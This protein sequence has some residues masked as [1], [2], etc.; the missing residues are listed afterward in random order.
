MAEALLGKDAGVA[1]SLLDRLIAEGKDVSRL[2]EDLITFFR[3]LLLLRTA[4]DLK[5]LLELISGD[6]RFVEMAKRF[7]LD[8]LYLFIDILAKTQQEM[9]FSNHA[10]VYIESALL[11]MI[12]LEVAQFKYRRAVIRQLIQGL[13]RKWQNLERRCHGV[14][15]TDVKW[16]Y[17]YATSAADNPHNRGK[18]HRNHRKTFK[19]PT[20]KIN[21]VLKAATK[22]DIQTIRE[23][24]AGMMQTMQKSHAALLEETEPVAASENAFVLKFKYEIHCLMASENASLRSGLSDALRSRTGKAYE[25]VYVPEEGWLKVREDFIR[26]NGLAQTDRNRKLSDEEAAQKKCFLL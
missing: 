4:P 2:A 9:R 6:D 24:W 7:E 18:M 13:R 25:V 14:A 21:E 22:Q 19:V 10:K 12:H 8:T 1:L 11:K 16:R 17:E 5:D 23:E 20:G 26:K 15:A 3:D